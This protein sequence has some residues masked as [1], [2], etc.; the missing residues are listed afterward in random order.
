MPVDP[1]VSKMNQPYKS[2]FNLLALFFSM[3]C[4]GVCAQQPTP[5][6]AITTAATSAPSTVPDDARYRIGAG[7][8][9]DIRVYNRPTLSRDGV[10]VEGNGMFR[11]PLIETEIQAACKTEGE[12][13]KDIS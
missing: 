4:V 12:V 13:A 11:M 8:V 9:L 1:G 5:N 3:C 6:P 2:R 10:R 7:D